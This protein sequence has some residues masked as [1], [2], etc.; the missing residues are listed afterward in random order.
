[1]PSLTALIDSP[2]LYTA[3]DG[4]PNFVHDTYRD[5]FL[6]RY[7]AEKINSGKMSVAEAFTAWSYPEE[8]NLWGLEEMV[9]EGE[10]TFL[11]A[12]KPVVFFL[13][14][15]VKDQNR[16]IRELNQHDPHLAARCLRY[17]S[18]L[19]EY[20]SQPEDSTAQEV[21]SKLSSR[22]TLDW[23][24]EQALAVESLGETRSDSALAPL[25]ER[26]YMPA[27]W[28]PHYEDKGN[29]LVALSKLPYLRAIETLYSFCT[30]YSLI[31]G[32]HPAYKRTA[33][34]ALWKNTFPVMLSISLWRKF[35]NG[36]L[37]Q[38][39]LLTGE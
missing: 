18:Q 19:N 8:R 21:V 39:A 20:M 13:T 17:C 28:G 38:L 15:L 31:T 27:F 24:Y 14:G 37:Y 33:F 4:R 5:F 1:M 30:N 9:K 16:F 11:P 23:A 6:A 12:W 35:E 7:F 32:R 26:L 34:L 29:V 25:T 2:L 10:R 22:L 3:S 36:E